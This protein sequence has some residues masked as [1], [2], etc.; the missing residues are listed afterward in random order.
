MILALLPPL[1]A[2]PLFWRAVPSTPF[3]F[4][5]LLCAILWVVTGFDLLL[6]GASWC[7]WAAL[8]SYISSMRDDGDDP[9][10]WDFDPHVPE[11]PRNFCKEPRRDYNRSI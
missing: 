11:G 3:L 5:W 7:I 6:Y 10:F 9:D 1:L 8:F 2:V 4:S